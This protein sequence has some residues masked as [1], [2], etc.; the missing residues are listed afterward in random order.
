MYNIRA[1]NDS[2]SYTYIYMHGFPVYVN[3]CTKLKMFN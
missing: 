3:D 1:T 2:K